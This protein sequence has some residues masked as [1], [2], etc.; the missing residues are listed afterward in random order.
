MVLA[1]SLDAG[2]RAGVVSAAGK[3]NAFATSSCALLNKKQQSIDLDASS[4]P[5][6]LHPNADGSGYY[7]FSLDEAGWQEL[8]ANALNLPAA[9]WADG[10]YNFG[11]DCSMS[12][13]EVAQRVASE[14]LSA[15]GKE[16]PVTTG[17]S[18][19]ESAAPV[20]FSID[21]LKKTGFS[22]D[23]VMREEIRGTFEVCERRVHFQLAGR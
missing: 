8:V 15:Y 10:L 16:V 23:G 6:R 3:F 17:G 20:Q 14:Y 9:E 12:I 1:D 13:L 4:C 2:F 19:T 21:K 7:R 11:G 5:T 22:L 18:G